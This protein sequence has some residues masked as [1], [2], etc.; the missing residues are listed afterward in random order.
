MMPPLDVQA[1]QAKL[2]ERARAA[3][4]IPYLVRDD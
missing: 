3:G 1:I 2:A 4:R